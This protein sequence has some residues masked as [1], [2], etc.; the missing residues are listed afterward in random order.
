[1]PAEP[2][3]GGVLLGSILQHLVV[4]ADDVLHLRQVVAE[5]LLIQQHNL[6]LLL[7]L[8]HPPLYIRQSAGSG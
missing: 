3:Q 2:T 6:L 4:L 5:L 7:Q 8:V 1:M